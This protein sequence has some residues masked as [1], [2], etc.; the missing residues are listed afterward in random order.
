MANTVHSNIQDLTIENIE[1]SPD[2][3]F[4]EK[5]SKNNSSLNILNQPDDTP[6][7][8]LNF[9]CNYKALGNI[10]GSLNDKFSVLSLNIQSI[11]TKFDELKELIEVMEKDGI[12]PDA[13]CLQ[14]VWNPNPESDFTICGYDPPIFK[15]R[16]IARG[17]GVGIYIKKGL[18]YSVDQVASVFIDRILETLIIHIKDKKQI[19]T[20]SSIYRPGAGHPTLSINDQ[21]SQSMDLLSGILNELETKNRT[22]YLFGDFNLDVL[23]YNSC[24]KVTEYV[25]LLF[26]FGFLQTIIKPTRCNPISASLIDHCVTNSKSNN[27]SSII[28]TNCLSDHFPILNAIESN[29]TV[30]IDNQNFTTRNFSTQN[31]NTFNNLLA[32]TDW[33]TVYNSTDVQTSFNLFFDEFFSTYNLIFPEITV[34]FNKNFHIKDPW[35]SNGFLTSRREKIRLSEA[36]ARVPSIE[37]ITKFKQ[38]R[39]LYHKLAKNAK[40][41]ILKNN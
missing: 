26:S 2:F 3:N 28:L 25:E 33:S 24:S 16:S 36:A 13:I 5:I 20:I 21:F 7:N 12:S 32:S 14:E 29:L 31:I 40:K 38:Y 9:S 11:N 4:L 35:F 23:K 10:S 34:K 41:S 22:A 37:N 27:F 15:L 1:G 17:G 18:T 8:S 39:N 6:Y 30:K 19:L